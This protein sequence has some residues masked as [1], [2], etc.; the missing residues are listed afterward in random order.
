[1]MLFVITT[2]L[3][4]VLTSIQFKRLERQVA[5]DHHYII[6]NRFN[7]LLTR[8]SI[9]AL[10]LFAV[11][12][13]VLNLSLFTKV[14]PVFKLI[15]T[16]E[17]LFFVI[18]F[19]G[20]LSIIWA[21]AFGVYRKLNNLNI[22]R[23]AFVLSNISFAVP[24][25][26][27]WV[28]LSGISDI[29]FALPLEWPKAWLSSTGGQ[30]SY[31]ITFLV[32]V[33][34]FGPALIHRFWWCSP[35]ENGEYRSRIAEL[36]Q[37]AGVKYA[38]ILYWPI[39][40]GR[41]ITAGV[42][43][44]FYKYRYILVTR[45]LLQSLEPDEMDAV[46]GH[47]IGHVKKKHL[48]FY[49]F[50]FAGYMF[51]A[52]AS[53][54]LIVYL[55]IFTEPA[56]RTLSKIGISQTSLTTGVFSVIMIVN[57]LIYFRF[58]FGYFM[59]NFERQADGYVYQLFENAQPLI[60][61]FRKIAAFSSQPS[62]KPNWHHFS[63][64][65]RVRYLERCEADRRWITRQDNKIRKSLVVYALGLLLVVTVGYQINYGETGRYIS[66]HVLVQ[67]ILNEIEKSPE[68]PKLIQTLGDVYYNI[69]QYPKAIDAYKSSLA[70]DP[71]NPTTLNNLAWLYATCED[72]R[73]VD[74]AM[75]LSLSQQ[76]LALDPDAPHIL[77]TLAESLFINGRIDEAI[78][79]EK[80]ALEL[81]NLDRH[82][83]LKQLEK[84]QN[85]LR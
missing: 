20:Y 11:D 30:V 32:L 40:G 58:V 66:E 80:R 33:S 37:K 53:F 55:L 34:V 62:D 22:S 5:R 26:L 38:D 72:D 67:I 2:L 51:I 68:N 45:A 70:M 73:Y 44:L 39:F 19:I 74:K 25:L 9:L 81:S 60:R 85:A 61:T 6:D 24:V 47:E 52:F 41:M 82:I 4:T 16:L 76:A 1:M 59:R 54:D 77:D 14:F 56:F 8:Y 71:D 21:L 48:L 28:L 7:A 31:F 27:P 50:F 63:I 12:I 23:S 84:F 18:L 65:E 79:T 36:C 43:G 69:K 49:L 83:Y 46:I 17:A 15:P 3:F 13:Y 75:A 64:S 29:L 10:A 35:L 57:F 78:E 42:M